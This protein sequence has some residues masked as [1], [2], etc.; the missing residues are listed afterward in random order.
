VLRLPSEHRATQ[1]QRDGALLNE[2]ATR[3]QT[4][5]DARA[6]YYSWARA[7]LQAAVAEQ[8]L[9]QA[10]QHRES[11]RSFFEAGT[12]SQA[13]VMRVEAQVASSE[14]FLAK[15]RNS[16]SVL[17]DRLRTLLHDESGAEYEIGDDL[18]P[19]EYVPGGSPSQLVAKAQANR[20]ELRSFD[21][22]IRASEAKADATRAGM[23]PHLDA[24]AALTTSNPNSRYLVQTGNFETTWAAGIQLTWS[25]NDVF[26]Y[27][28]A[29]RSADARTLQLAAQRGALRDQVRSEVEQDVAELRRAHIA[30]G[31]TER[32]LSAAEE[33]YRV[34]RELFLN[35]RA[36]SVELIDA[37][38][39]LTQARLDAVS[40]RIDQ[41]IARVRLEHSAGRDLS[42]LD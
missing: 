8:A 5:A 36:T 20:L 6:A 9:A 29:A 10:R 26:S 32:G 17:E 16:E 40:A 42:T 25:P 1:R 4:A 13:D 37:E 33:S 23:I 28:A 35:G 2:R 18:R 27:K 41:Q 21:E 31:A 30:I 3:L 22:S 12:S 38:T 14:L 7:R 19:L 11:V 39:E 34:R 24:F 15:A